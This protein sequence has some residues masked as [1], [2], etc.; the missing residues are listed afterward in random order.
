MRVLYV[1]HLFFLALVSAYGSYSILC[2]QQSD[3]AHADFHQKKLDFRRG[4]LKRSTATVGPFLDW[5]FREIWKDVLDLNFNMISWD[6]F[7]IMAGIFPF[8]IATRMIDEKIHNCFYE[9]NNHK[10]L[11]QPPS[12]I[13]NLAEKGIGIPIVILGSRAFLSREFDQQKTA[14]IYLTGLP[15]VIWGKDLIKTL[16][17]DVCY[18]PWNEKFSCDKR[19][20]GGFP[21]G[22][23]AE[24]V[25]TAVLYGLQYGY[26]YALPLGVLATFIGATFVVCNRHYVSQVFAGAGL[27]AMYAVAAHKLVDVR[28]AEH[29]LSLGMCAN[30]GGAALT[31]SYRF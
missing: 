19:A 16:E 4:C 10:N 1:Y 5:M 2:A 6:S 31:L 7:K 22:H 17:F 8:F 18:R 30:N 15:F 24:A 23:M 12:W 3:I 26:E 27:G 13:Y 29:K 20:Y 21:S 11:H 14:Q 28:L 25:Y 9:G